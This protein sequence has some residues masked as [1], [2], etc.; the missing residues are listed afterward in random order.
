MVAPPKE[1]F[2]IGEGVTWIGSVRFD[3]LFLEEIG[4]RGDK[5]AKG[6]YIFLP[7]IS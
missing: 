4:Y 2:S 3:W 7:E 5:R 6:K 1:R